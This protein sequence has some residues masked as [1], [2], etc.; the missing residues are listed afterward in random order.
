MN[1]ACTLCIGEEIFVVSDAMTTHDY[2][3]HDQPVTRLASNESDPVVG[4]AVLE[5]LSLYRTNATPSGP[6]GTEAD[7]VL[8]FAGVRT[9]GQL[10]RNSH[11]ILIR[12]EAGSITSIPTRH[13]QGGGYDHLNELAIHC[14]AIPEE[15]GA[16]VRQAIKLCE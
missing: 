4:D 11:C 6:M 5:A 14:Q 10:E 15:I 8:Q 1:R 2:Y 3:E 13:A 9:W 12:E 16:A 7:P